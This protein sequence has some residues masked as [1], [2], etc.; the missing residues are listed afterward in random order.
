MLM[1]MF[2]Q[3]PGEV[4]YFRTYKSQSCQKTAK[5]PTFLIILIITLR[6]WIDRYTIKE[7]TECGSPFV[8]ENQISKQFR[9]F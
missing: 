5:N 3:H 4:K 2:T 1:N 7:H 9:R 8:V 6:G